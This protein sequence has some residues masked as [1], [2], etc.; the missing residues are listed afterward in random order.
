[1]NSYTVLLLRPDYMAATFGQDTFL[2]HVVANG[3]A[4]AVHIAQFRAVVAD[5]SGTDPIDYVPLFVC[6]GHQRNL[7]P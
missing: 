3:P 1:M 7:A 2:A 6:L 4:D 5:G